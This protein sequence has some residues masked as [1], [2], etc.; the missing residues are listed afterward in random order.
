MANAIQMPAVGQ[1]SDEFTIVA[2]LKAEGDIVALGEPLFTVETDKA[3]L[4]IESAF[5][6]TVLKIVHPAQA[7]VHT[8]DVLVYIGAPGEAIPATLSTPSTPTTPTTPSTPAP[9]PPTL[10]APEGKVL[11]APAARQLAREHGI[12]LSRVQGSGPGGR[13]E[14]EDVQRAIASWS[15]L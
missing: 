7:I 4:E 11:A 15:K 3:T 6:G 12:D 2:W 1:V 14:K 10:S 13:I 8:G 9:P 5:A